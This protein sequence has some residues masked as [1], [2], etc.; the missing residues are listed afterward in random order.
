MP[1]TGR[2]V[3]AAVAELP[4]GYFALVMATGIV[5]EALHLDR[6]E[7]PS[8]VLAVLAVVAYAALVVGCGWRVLRY[9]DRFTADVTDPAKAF[10][11]FTFVAASNVLAARFAA[12]QPVP[13]TALAAVGALAWLV[14]G[15]GTPVT[16]LARHGSRPALAAANGTWFLWVVGT[17]SVAVAATALPVHGWATDLAAALWSVGTAGYLMVA[18]LVL[19]A[20]LLF[21]ARPADI[22]PPYWVFMGAT[23]IS[24]LAGAQLLARPDDALLSAVR[25][26][27]AGLSV[28]LWAMGSWL[29]P[30]LLVLGAWRHLVGRV[31]LRYEPGLWSIVFPIGMHGVASHRLGEVLHVRWL[32][33]VGGWEAW[34][35]LAVWFATF[36]YLIAATIV[37]DRRPA[38]TGRSGQSG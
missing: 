8:A 5:S 14:L 35:G 34:L 23:A 13:A 11:P 15:Y 25:P 33:R 37:R 29:I 10:E 4:P 9:R 17:Q 20:L 27:V 32:A 28:V 1:V 24:A 31:P 22:T 19:T 7:G 12:E 30:L 18:V 3:R 16:L 38:G 2:G 26:V 6:A 21:G 36:G